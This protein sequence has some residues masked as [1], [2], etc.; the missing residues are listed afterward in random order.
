MARTRDKKLCVSTFFK[1]QIDLR[2]W[3]L[4][5]KDK[6]PPGI[7]DEIAKVRNPESKLRICFHMTSEFLFNPAQDWEQRI[8][9]SI[10]KAESLFAKNRDC[11]ETVKLILRSTEP[12]LMEPPTPCPGSEA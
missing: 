2:L 9:D 4:E 5:F 3:N 1:D 8:F 10:A 6:R 12:F 7:E 11:G